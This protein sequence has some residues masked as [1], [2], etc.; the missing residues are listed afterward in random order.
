MSFLNSIVA[1]FAMLGL[2][3]A[4]VPGSQNVVLKNGKGEV[5]GSAVISPLVKGVKIQMDVHGLP[6]GEHAV[7]FHE[8][9]ICQGPKFDSAGGHFAPEKSKHGFDMQGG[10]HAGNM[11]NFFV[12]Q[13]GTAKVELINTKVSL[14]ADP[15]S[16]LKP[17]GTALVIH[18]KADDYKTQPSGDAGGRFACG[19]IKK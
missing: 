8:K 13:D 10:P 14:G 2:A 18:E 3:N 17:G 7:H 9:G 5:V 19:E 12:A 1:C 11:P 16:L 15:D 4:A 6:P